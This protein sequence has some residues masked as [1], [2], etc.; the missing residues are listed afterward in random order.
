MTKWEEKGED[1]EKR[2]NKGDDDDDGGGGGDLDRKVIKTL[3]A[4][5]NESK[6]VS[7][8]KRVIR[9]FI[10]SHLEYPKVKAGDQQ[11][12]SSNFQYASPQYSCLMRHF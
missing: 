9:L 1:V 10:C 11:Q 3:A 4:N 6:N 8:N 7:I 2:E 5:P 12:I